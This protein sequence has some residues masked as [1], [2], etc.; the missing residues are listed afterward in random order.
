M[1]RLVFMLWLLLGLAPLQTARALDMQDVPEPL[2][3]WV[4]WVLADETQYRCP[5]IFDDFQQK[6]CA[7]P[8]ALHLNLQAKHGSF[9]AEWTVYRQDWISLPGDTQHWPQAVTV[10]KQ[11]QPVVE[12]DGKPALHLPAGRYQISGEF[13]WENLPEQLALPEASGLIQLSVNDKPVAYPPIKQGALWLNTEN[14]DTADREQDR[15]DL[16]VFRQ[17]QDEVPLQVITRLDLEVSGKAREIEFPYALLPN[18]IPV[19]LN[20]SLPA[21]LDGNGRLLVQVRP[22]RWSIE[23]HGRHPQALT[24]L[25][26]AVKDENWPAQELW[27]F[28]AVPALRL[29]EIENLTAIDGSQTNLPAEWQHLPTY[30]LKQGE[31]MKF[32]VMRRGDPEPEPNQL[33]LK[34]TLW[35]DFEGGGYTVSDNITGTMSRDWRLNAVPELGLGQ[36]QLDG[37]SQLITQ[38]ADGKQGVEVRRGAIQLNADSRIEADLGS[39]NA[40]G[41]QQRFQQ[42]Q[43]ELNIPPGWRLLA[44]SGVDNVP[45]SWLSCWTLLDLFLVLIAGL[46]VGRIWSPQ[47]G[48]FALLSLTLIWHEADA[49]RLIWLNVLAVLALLRVLPVGGFAQW[50]RWYR[51]ASWLALLMLTIPFMIEQIRIGIYPQLELPEQSIQRLHSMA[52]AAAPMAMQVEQM[53]DSAMAPERSDSGEAERGVYFKKSVVPVSPYGGSSAI[54]QRVDPEANLQTGPGLPHWGW[55]KVDL[56]WNGAVDN[57]QQIGLW[58]L[59]PFMMML[60]HFA[61]AAL[62]AVL[63]LKMLGA[64]ASNWRLSLPGLSC[65]LLLPLLMAPSEKTYADLPDAQMLEQLKARLLQAPQCLPNCAQ[66]ADMQLMVKP[67]MLRIELQLH[68]QQDLAIPLPAQLEQW[69]PEQVSVDGGEAQALI[70][71]DDGSL[72]LVVNAGIHKVT[73]QSRYAAQD[74]FSLPLPLPPQH[75]SV[76]ADGWRVDGLYEDGKVGPQ[77]EFSR[78][79]LDTGPKNKL[80]QTA[81][82]AFVRVERTLHL[83]LDWRVTTRVEQLAGALSPVSLELPLLPGEAV[84]SPQVRIKD[85]KVLVNMAAGQATLEWESALAKTEQLT[86]QAADTPQWTEV[87][88]ADVSPIWHLQADGIAVVHHQDGQG[89][90]LP[91]WRPWPGEKVNLTIGRPQAVVGSTLTIDRSELAV[92][93]G[94]RSETV[95]LILSIRSSKGGQHPVKLP[96]Q[97]ELQSVT[98]DGV[99]QPIRQQG[100]TVSLPIHPGT[101]QIVLNWQTTKE[102]GVLLRTP[103]VDLGVASV[104]SR[105]QVLMPQQRWLLWT[106]GPKFG[107]AVL[108]WGLLIVLALLAF[109]FGKL[110]ITPL[111]HWQWFLLLIGLSQLHIAAAFLVVGWLFALGFRAHHAPQRPRWFNLAQIGLAGLTL[112]SLLLIAIAVEQGLLGEPDMQ[113]AGN[114]SSATLLNWYQDRNGPQLAVATVVSLPLLAYRILML[115]WSLWMAAALLNWLRWGWNC[116][117]GGGLWKKSQPQ[118]G[119]PKSEA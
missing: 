40:S 56:S 5:F 65:L 90:W 44:V 72:W 46:A 39:I 110:S 48:A 75:A 83:G 105:I 80:Q 98:I 94:Q 8:G 55:Q 61:Q 111:Q 73:M 33:K 68:A 24:Q 86:L 36:V 60:L 97:A 87:W 29:V 10:N 14:A 21:R 25:D 18:F 58:Y 43:A 1:G 108:I 74:K 84:T 67:E 114:Q 100:A 41:W 119:V 19:A 76:N 27:A 104:N 20:S 30:Q 92:K 7:W 45:N 2:K 31:S 99:S 70:R 77:L 66:I 49:P 115:A 57:G 96:E 3:P 52:S 81:L 26:L 103:L 117:I 15:L 107:P 78:L 38:L 23:I 88:R 54:L 79:Q 22:G 4:N 64:I 47:W 63:V 32:K 82:P 95:E 91:E 17:V 9:V 42:V 109:G 106:F 28:Q 89:Q 11:T 101:Q 102:P 34:R 50:L 93:P 12:K 118:V 35:L 6:H 51:N 53:T 62:V 16:Q 116:F 59:S 37:Q 69:F 85:G 112:L 13:F 71:Q 113:I